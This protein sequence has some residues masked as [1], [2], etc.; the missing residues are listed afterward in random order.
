MVP[1]DPHRPTVSRMSSM[2]VLVVA[3]PMAGH[4]LPLVPLAR[5]LRDAGHEGVVGTTGDPLRVCPEARAAED[6]APRLR[7]FPLMLP[8]AAAHPLLARK[9]NA[10][11]D[12]ARAIGRLWA[13][14]NQR[15]SGGLEALA[16][17]LGRGAG[18]Y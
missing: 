4:L 10:G 9:A 6:V 12:D 17:R 18:V 16:D 13:P 15:M 14:V 7:L 8:F 2:R 1:T 11:R 3:T 5:A